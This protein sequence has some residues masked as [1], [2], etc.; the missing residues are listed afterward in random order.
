MSVCVNKVGLYNL[1]PAG[2]LTTPSITKKFIFVPYFKEDGTVNSIDLSLP[3][4]ETEIDALINQSDKNLRWYPT[5]TVSNF[6]TE[7]ADP[8][9]ETIDNVDYIISEGVRTMSGDFISASAG[10]AKK[11]NSNNAV[12]V[13]VYLVDSANG[14]TGIKSGCNDLQPIRLEK[15]QFGKV[16]FPTESNIFKVMWSATWSRLITD[17]CLVTLCFDDHKTD[18][19]SKN[20]LVDVKFCN[21]SVVDATTFRISYNIPNGSAKGIAFTGLL[22]SDFLLVNSTTNTLMAISAVA[23]FSDGTYE[24]T[25]TAQNAGELGTLSVTKTGFEFEDA[26]IEFV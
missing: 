3:F 21:E 26:T 8:I 14:L 4:G 5:A 9:T 17:G 12:E 15:N 7:R 2:C 24:V 13:G 23:E 18:V 1:Q 20:G 19:L 16:V 11:I 10:L 6:V 25:Y 22:A